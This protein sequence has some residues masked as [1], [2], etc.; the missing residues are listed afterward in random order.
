MCGD[1][2]SVSDE[3]VSE[4]DSLAQCVTPILHEIYFQVFENDAE[5][6]RQESNLVSSDLVLLLERRRQTD[7]AIDGCQ[8][9][10]R[11]LSGTEGA[12]RLQLPRGCVVVDDLDVPRTPYHAKSPTPGASKSVHT[13]GSN[14]CTHSK[15]RRGPHEDHFSH[16][17]QP[18]TVRTGLGLCVV[19]QR[20]TLGTARPA[21]RASPADGGR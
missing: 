8:R 14:Q 2:Q 6:G 21:A 12:L 10:Y 9:T 11:E 19:P 5:L 4:S 16:N 17:H 15:T 20:T 18:A 1:V 3:S 7:R 13:L